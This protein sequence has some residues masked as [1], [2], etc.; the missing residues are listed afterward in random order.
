MCTVCVSYLCTT[1]Y[2]TYNCRHVISDETPP[3][4]SCPLLLPHFSSPDSPRDRWDIRR[5]LRDRVAR[6]TDRRMLPLQRDTGKEGALV[7]QSALPT[8]YWSQVSGERLDWL[9]AY[10]FC[11]EAF[12]GAFMA[13]VKTQEQQV[14]KGRRKISPPPYSYY[15]RIPFTEF[16]DPHKLLQYCRLWRSG[17][18]QLLDR[19]KRCGTRGE[20]NDFSDFVS[21]LQ[22]K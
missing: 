8:L 20:V 12:P 9:T 3:V 21:F 19:R 6:G 18:A 2:V 7:Y 22:R 1:Y 13:E 15:G 16:P 10:E 5:G 17:Q 4:P 14:N 11:L